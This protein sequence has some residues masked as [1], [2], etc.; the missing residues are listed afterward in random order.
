MAKKEQTKKKKRL[1]KE[2]IYIPCKI[3]GGEL[4]YEIDSH[5]KPRVYTSLDNLK[6]N[7]TD[8]DFALEYKLIKSWSKEELK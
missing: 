7:N 3:K 2:R 4:L 6:K 1:S 5:E 8:F